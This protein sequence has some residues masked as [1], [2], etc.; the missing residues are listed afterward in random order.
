MK[1][2]SIDIQIESVAR[3]T[4]QRA[5]ISSDVAPRVGKYTENTGGIQF[6]V[7]FAPNLPGA[8]TGL[9]AVLDHLQRYHYPTGGYAVAIG[10]FRD[11]TATYIHNGVRFN[12]DGT[13][14]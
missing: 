7:E 6:V 14:N 2:A 10:S 8:P 4:Q 5:T 13:R 9:Q 3:R 11:Y 12:L 1:V